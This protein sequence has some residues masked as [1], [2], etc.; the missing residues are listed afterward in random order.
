[1]SNP[2][3]PDDC[4]YPDFDPENIYDN[5]PDY[6]SLRDAYL[7]LKA[8]VSRD[9]VRLNSGTILLTVCGERVHYVAQDLR[10]AIDAGIAAN[11][12]ICL[13]PDNEKS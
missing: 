11:T 13:T 10:A 6:V 2:N 5:P 12:S 4:P 8:S 1:M 3:Y 7:E 9:T